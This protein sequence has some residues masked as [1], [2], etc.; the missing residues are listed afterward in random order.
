MNRGPPQPLRKTRPVSGQEGKSLLSHSTQPVQN[1][2]LGVLL[3]SSSSNKL[4]WNSFDW[5]GKGPAVYKLLRPSYAGNLRPR[6]FSRCCFTR[7][8]ITALFTPRE[9]TSGVIAT[10]PEESQEG[11]F[12]SKD[13]VRILYFPMCHPWSEKRILQS[14]NKN[15]GHELVS[16]KMTIANRDYEGIGRIS[17]ARRVPW[18]NDG[19]H[20]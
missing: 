7:F 14:Q 2:N 15:L 6:S 8:S 9:V 3:P 17:A 19:R 1:A 13:P 10:W 11:Q 20:V 18:Q 5:K 16:H 4:I 12:V